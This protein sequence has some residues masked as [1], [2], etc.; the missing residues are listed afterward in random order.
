MKWRRVVALWRFL[1]P[2][3]CVAIVPDA[4]WAG[5]I[6]EPVIRIV[7]HAAKTGNPATLQSAID[8]A[9]ATNPDSVAEIDALA[10]Q[11]RKDAD[12]ARIAKLSSEAFFEGWT[13][14]GEAGASL[15][16]GTS[17]NKTL[18]L[19]VHLAKEDL[20]WRHKIALIGNYQSSNDVTTAESYLA[21]YEGNYRFAPRLYAFGL[22]QWEQD[23]FAGFN[24]RYSESFGAGYTL[25]VTPAFNWQVSSGP[26]LRQ[27]RRVTHDAQSDASL[28]ADSQLLWSISPSTAFNEEVGTYAGGSDS[29]YFSTTAITTKVMGNLSARTSFNITSESNPP[30]GIETTNTVTRLTLVYSF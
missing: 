5:P 14:E 23:R 15:T 10:A 27:T 6:P 19:G 26:A 18:A 24:A 13:G 11:L 7:L 12:A 8:L 20:E 25:V 29:T 21:S 3:L 9:K 17:D 1:F 4:A 30:V 28:R 2:F 16:T 22:L